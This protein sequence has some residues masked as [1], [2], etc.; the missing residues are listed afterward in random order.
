MPMLLETPPAI[1]SD[2]DDAP[3]SLA[4]RLEWAETSNQDCRDYDVLPDG[5]D[6]LDAIWEEWRAEAET[7]AAAEM[8]GVC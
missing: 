8:V 6:P 7:W 4:A 3:P 2:F 1:I 5:P